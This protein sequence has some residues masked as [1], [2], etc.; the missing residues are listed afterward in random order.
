MLKNFL[1]TIQSL[2]AFDFAGAQRTAISE[3]T[4][5]LADMQT[6]QFATGKDKEGEEILLEGNGYAFGT[7][8]FKRLFGR[9][10]GAVI[11]HVTL[12]QTGEL[13]RQTFAEI[14]MDKVTFSSRVPYWAELIQRT[15]DVTGINKEN[16][17][18]FANGFVLPFVNNQL[19]KQTGLIIT[20]KT[21]VQL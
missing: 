10:L 1:T 15:G 20:N 18:E 16:A 3:N 7:V 2:S 11:D 13:Y 6:E 4:E 12:F 19:K 17:R 9:G 8:V 5:V 14:N 21:G